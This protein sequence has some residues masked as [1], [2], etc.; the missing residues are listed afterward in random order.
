[1]DCRDWVEEVPA[2]PALRLETPSPVFVRTA[3]RACLVEDAVFVG[4]T[5]V[6]FRTAEDGNASSAALVGALPQTQEAGASVE[7]WAAARR[8]ATDV[9]FVARAFGRDGVR[10]TLVGRRGESSMPIAA[11]D[12][13]RPRASLPIRRGL[14]MSRTCGWS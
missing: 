4:R 9:M 1:M 2:V 5:R 12:R 11:I 10:V 13:P 6:P 8:R 14:R 3:P 7:R